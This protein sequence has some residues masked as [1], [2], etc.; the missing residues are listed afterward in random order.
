MWGAQDRLTGLHDGAGGVRFFFNGKP[1]AAID[2]QGLRSPVLWHLAVAQD[3]GPRAAQRP[4]RQG[5][6][7]VRHGRSRTRH[8]MALWPAGLALA[9]VSLPLYVTLPRHYAEQ[10]AVPLGTLGVL[11]LLTRLLDAVLDPRIGHWVDQLFARHP[12]QSWVA[13]LLASVLMAVGFAALWTPPAS[14][15][16]TRNHLL[17]WLAG[18]LVVT[19]LAYS[20]ASM[21]HQAW[22]ARWG[23]QPEQRA[24]LVAWREGAALAGGAAGQPAARVVGLASHQR[25]P[26]RGAGPWVCGPCIRP[27]DAC[28]P[29]QRQPQTEP[30]RPCDSRC[31]WPDSPGAPRAF[32]ALL[33]VFLLNGTA[34]AMPATL[35]PFFVRDSLQAPTWEAAVPGQLLPGRGLRPATVGEAD[36]AHRP[37]PGLAA[38][39]GSEACWPFAPCLGLARAMPWRS[40]PSACSP[41]WPWGPTWP[42]P[43]HCSPASSTTRAW[44]S[45]AKAASLAGGQPPPKLN[46]ALASGLALPLLAWVGYETGRHTPDNQ[47][48]MALTYGLLPCVFKLL[49][50][51]ALWRAMRR[52]PVLRGQA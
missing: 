43:A 13:A 4:H 50:A 26:G 35:L 47:F 38:G 51:A 36:P 9:F 52:H 12:R 18:A 8:R 17:A 44:A 29:P 27:C 5:L 28:P 34:S 16:D 2:G 24:R 30:H 39:H 1:T 40:R 41:A 20:L 37:G 22:G 25:G 42:S 7:H 14:V 23:G 48:A 6:K 15:Q 31:A 32:V 11:L 46:L 45:K 21:V 49:A 33:I 19:Y 10:Y 3:L